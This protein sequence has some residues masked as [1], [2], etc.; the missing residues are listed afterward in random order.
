MH[1]NQEEV[2]RMKKLASLLGILSLAA[3]MAACGP[4]MNAINA[5]TQKAE[6]DANNANTAAQ[7]AETS[8]QQAQAAA[9]KADQG[10]TEAQDSVR[11][12]ND[13]VARLEAAFSTSVTK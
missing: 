2:V 11:R 10:A 5:A 4:D 9:Q 1:W 8:A 3:F 12:A 13:A 7:N 6:T